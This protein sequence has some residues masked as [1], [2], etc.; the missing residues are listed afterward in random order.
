MK[1]LCIFAWNKKS[2]CENT[3]LPNGNN[4]FSHWDLPKKVSL[5]LPKA[6]RLMV[7]GS[8]RRIPV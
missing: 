5:P 8:S 4:I 2:Q 7:R 6:R 1:A 3:L